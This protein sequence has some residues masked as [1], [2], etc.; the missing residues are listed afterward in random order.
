T[1]Q[2]R[3]GLWR[4]V[5]DKQPP[6]YLILP[7]ALKTPDGTIDTTVGQM[8]FRIDNESPAVLKFDLVASRF[9][10]VTVSTYEPDDSDLSNVKRLVDPAITVELRCDGVPPIAAEPLP[11]S[12]N[13][14]ITGEYAVSKELLSETPAVLSATSC[15]VVASGAGYGDSAKVLDTELRVSSEPVPLNP[16][17]SLVVLPPPVT[18][19]GRVA[20]FDGVEPVYVPDAVVKSTGLAIV[21]YPP[22]E[23]VDERPIEPVAVKAEVTATWDTATTNPSGTTPELS[24]FTLDQ[25]VY[26]SA[27]Y[28]VTSPNIAIGSFEVTIDGD[29][30]EPLSDPVDIAYLA[31]TL[32]PIAYDFTLTEPDPGV[33]E[34]CLT[35][36]TVR[37]APEF[38]EALEYV[39]ATPAP[40]TTALGV[41]PAVA[42]CVGEAPAKSTRILTDPASAGVWT[43]DYRVDPA[44]PAGDHPWYAPLFGQLPVTQRIDPGQTQGGFDL[45]LVEN[46][47][48]TLTV[49]STEPGPG[50]PDPELSPTYVLTPYV[51]DAWD[52][53]A[54]TTGRCG[55]PD[56]CEQSGTVEIRGVPVDV[57]SP[58]D[59]TTSSI[60]LTVPGFDVTAATLPFTSATTGSADIDIALAAGQEAAV[61]VTVEPLGEITGSIKGYV[62]RSENIETQGLG[63]LIAD[64]TV[65][66]Q[67]AGSDWS[68][69]GTAELTKLSDDEIGFSVGDEPE[70]SYEFRVRAANPSTFPY[71]V[72]TGDVLDVVLPPTAPYPMTNAVTNPIGTLR[73][74]LKPAQLAVHLFSKQAVPLL[75]AEFDVTMKVFRSDGVQIGPDNT[76]G[77][78][79]WPLDGSGGVNPGLL[80]Q[81]GSYR[82]ELS[83]RDPLDLD[84]ADQVY[85]ASIQITLGASG[86]QV[87][88]I[89]PPTSYS[90][91]VDVMV[92]NSQWSVGDTATT[93][94][95]PVPSGITVTRS[96]DA[97]DA[98]LT[99]GGTTT[100]VTTDTVPGTEAGLTSETSTT[101]GAAILETLQFPR[102]PS[103]LHIVT[104]GALP[105]GYAIK[106]FFVDSVDPND[107]A[108]PQDGSV[109]V[110]DPNG[111]D[112]D[113]TK[114]V[115]VLVVD[116][117]DVTVNLSPASDNYPDLDLTLT[118]PASGTPVDTFSLLD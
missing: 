16:Y 55:P 91:T 111:A 5:V 6:G 49:E 60:G 31:S 65:E 72:A 112:P 116:D 23:D 47:T 39:G 102:I 50:A 10:T 107:A 76:P 56:T 20:W 34:G 86:L 74:E 40:A 64:I 29:D 18:I 37:V 73:L 3:N 77:T 94:R 113:A 118:F 48:I 66:Y 87:D 12:G 21:G 106:T 83:D 110:P 9:P 38:A 46:G 13:G 109:L 58:L 17:V 85:P 75:P 14:G 61:T 88:V 30:A 36:A 7:Q 81:P 63:L 32:P 103:G 15:S 79:A 89:L 62:W 69:P 105:T 33:L 92:V 51:G 80:L 93:N 101:T 95:L 22:T 27:T 1:D 42:A 43:V 97:P 108:V 26:G 78:G 104:P 19:T 68:A 28:T 25:Q 57:V 54:V 8:E 98:V 70:G 59:P 71:R 35:V 114:L 2:L 99:G 82:L 41:D 4:I 90:L 11:T 44:L 100:I 96:F 117:V 52:A 115:L 84:Q 45:T 67:L 24:S 53:A